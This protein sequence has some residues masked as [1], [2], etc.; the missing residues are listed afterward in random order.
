[1][2]KFKKGQVGNPEGGRVHNKVK[3]EF[4]RLTQE[5]LREIMILILYTHPER[6]EDELKN[7][8]TT[9]LKA[10]IAAAAV[11]GINNGDISTLNSLLDRVVG[12]VEDKLDL[13]SGGKSI[14]VTFGRKDGNSAS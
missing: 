1:M 6:L 4:K 12:K 2:P 3:R 13:T 5:Q 9:V 14:N 10:W 8:D 11:K 7:A